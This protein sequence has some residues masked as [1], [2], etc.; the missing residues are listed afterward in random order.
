MSQQVKQASENP[1]AIIDAI[2]TY[3]DKKKKPKRNRSAFILFSID[4]R[5]KLNPDGLDELN[6][7]DK[8]VK[9]AQLW[10]E[11]TEEERKD[12]EERAKR[13]KIRYTSELTDFCKVF[14]SEPIQRPR[15]HI[16]KPCN[17]YGYF[18]KDMKEDIR[19]ENPDLRM[20]EVLRIVGERWKCLSVDD[21]QKYEKEAEI[22]RKKFKADVSKQN[23]QNLKKQKLAKDSIKPSQDKP[24]S[25]QAP[26]IKQESLV[27]KDPYISQFEEQKSIEKK[28]DVPVN[29]PM[30]TEQE[31]ILPN[32]HH[33]THQ[34]PS[35]NLIR[36]ETIPSF[37]FQ[38]RSDILTGSTALSSPV[39][40][41]NSQREMTASLFDLYYRVEGL[42]QQILGQ[43]STV[44]QGGQVMPIN[45]GQISLLEQIN[46][47][48][49]REQIN[50]SLRFPLFQ[51]ESKKEDM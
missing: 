9:I 47:S 28:K 13:E 24:R 10:R 16:K 38:Q 34:N 5:K 2:S 36:P 12:Y 4:I 35:P 23:L 31:N 45:F 50:N 32:L 18:L 46:Q 49:M 48:V 43:L 21:K 22:S 37:P 26:A 1:N 29:I 41:D 14:P 51:G 19:K 25:P 7:N 17:A 15:N 42:R 11:I 3:T 30:Y 27:C 44:A 20:C 40:T 8:F 6:P 33:Q 39:S